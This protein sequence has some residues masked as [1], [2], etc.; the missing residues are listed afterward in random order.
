[1][2]ECTELGWISGCR[3]AGCIKKASPD[4]L[5]TLLAIQQVGVKRSL[6]I[7][8]FALEPAFDELLVI[9]VV[10]VSLVPLPRSVV[11]LNQVLVRHPVSI[12]AH[13]VLPAVPAGAVWEPMEL[14]VVHM[15]VMRVEPIIGLVPVLVLVSMELVVVVLSVVEIVIVEV[16]IVD[17]VVVEFLI[18]E[19]TN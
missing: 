16:A 11:I 4:V 12:E 3:M 7:F 17:V 9:V 10:E 5:A 18:V 15:V 2:R 1:M 6:L 8:Q 13:P 19:V 14:D